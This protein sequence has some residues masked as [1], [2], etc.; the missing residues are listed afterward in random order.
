MA[1]EM[2]INPSVCDSSGDRFSVQFRNSARRSE[3]SQRLLERF[4][5]QCSG[6]WLSEDKP[7]KA[8]EAGDVP[9]R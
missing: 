4:Q 8:A 2:R 1:R 7:D 6:F 3:K 5:G 9:H